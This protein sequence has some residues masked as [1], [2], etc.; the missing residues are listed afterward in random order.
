MPMSLHFRPARAEDVDAAIPLIYSSGP[1]AFDYVFAG[2]PKGSAQDFLR[3]AFVSGAGQ[4]GYRQHWLGEQDGQ[5]VAAGTVYL[6]AHVHE[7]F[8]HIRSADSHVEAEHARQCA[9]L[10]VTLHRV[11]SLLTRGT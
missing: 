11:R 1:A 7:S 8:G 10:R 5:V 9:E 4:F 2:T 3:K 6:T